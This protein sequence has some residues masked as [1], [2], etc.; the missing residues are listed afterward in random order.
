MKGIIRY[1]SNGKPICE[2]CGKS[3]NRLLCHV[4]QKHDLSEKQYKSRF[5]LDLHKGICS[6]ESAE[7]TRIKTLSNYDTCIKRNLVDRGEGTRFTKGHEGRTKDKISE[8][9]LRRLKQ[10]SFIKS[11]P[12][13]GIV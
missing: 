3:F 13:T 6:K 1:D 12:E 10:T 5:G 4:R 8:Q 2:L 11:N 7:R 9:T